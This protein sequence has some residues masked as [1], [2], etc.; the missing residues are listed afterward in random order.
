MNNLSDEQIAEYKE[1]FSLF[2]KDG[3]GTI[4]IKELKTVMKSL[5]QNYSDDEIKNMIDNVD[6]NGDGF[7]DFS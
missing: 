4:N 6:I 2:D 1:A 5:N 3:D 7:I